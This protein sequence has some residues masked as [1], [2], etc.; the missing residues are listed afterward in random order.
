MVGHLQFMV[1]QNHNL[2]GRILDFA[3][4]FSCRTECPVCFS[5]GRT[6]FDFGRTLPD[7]QPL[8]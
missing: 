1:R 4:S 5:F 3:L 8:F 7:V 2:V 6:N